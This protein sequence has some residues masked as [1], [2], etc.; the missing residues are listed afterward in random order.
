MSKSIDAP[1]DRVIRA[2]LDRYV[3]RLP[4]STRRKVD[5]LLRRRRE[6]SIQ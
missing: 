3:E 6:R 4:L 2:L 1:P 5:E